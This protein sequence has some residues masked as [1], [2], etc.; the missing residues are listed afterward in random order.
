MPK[1]CT[2]EATIRGAPTTL[3]YLC[4]KTATTVSE[5]HTIYVTV[6]EF[7]TVTPTVTSE[8]KPT[9]PPTAA[10][11]LTTVVYIVYQPF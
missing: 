2:D 1:L 6:T 4:P 11:G 3:T 7:T 5:R 8:A 10:L 9:V